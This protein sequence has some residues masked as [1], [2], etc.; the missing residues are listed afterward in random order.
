MDIWSSW[1]T[2]SARATLI[3]SGR[4]SARAARLLA[5]GVVVACAGGA[6]ESGSAPVGAAPRDTSAMIPA[7]FGSLHQED[8]AISVAA[9]ALT[10]RAIPLDEDFIRVLSPDSYR[11]LN[12]QRESRRVAI[13]AIA[14]RTGMQTLSLW[15]VQFYNLQ[16]GEARFSTNDVVLVNQ[17]RDFRP[18]DVIPITPG[19]GEQ[20][21]RQGQT[22]VAILVFDGA[23]NP[24]QPPL[25]L[26]FGAFT[27]GNWESVLRRVETERS[28][29]RSRAGA[30]G[31][32]GAP[33]GTSQW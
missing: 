10:V 12:G 22:A 31:R 28:R 13:D 23:V 24:N 14:Q 3:A 1:P 9:N 29:I 27:G 2:W 33:G 6:Y 25:T 30:A 20:R 5:V 15:Y 4:G 21:V 26:T 19:F 7:G 16:P 17:G 18:L 8:I 11:S 32:G